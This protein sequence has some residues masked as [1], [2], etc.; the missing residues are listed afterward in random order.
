MEI[1]IDLRFSSIDRGEHSASFYRGLKN[2]G[3]QAAEQLIKFKI[4]S[5]VSQKL[6]RISSIRSVLY[7]PTRDLQFRGTGLALALH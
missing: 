5:K 6:Y 2:A 1:A 3:H 4:A 7:S